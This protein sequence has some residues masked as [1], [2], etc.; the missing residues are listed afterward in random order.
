MTTH[1]ET[2]DLI[3]NYDPEAPAERYRAAG[4]E[5]AL[6]T[7]Q[8]RLPSTVPWPADATPKAAPLE[9]LPSETDSLVRF[10]GY[11][12]VVLTWTAAEAASRAALNTPDY[13]P[14]KWYEYRHAIAD[15]VP[16]VI[17]PRA[18]FN[19]TRADMKRYFHSLGLY[20]PCT[21]GRAKV[22]L[23][24]SGL[25]LDYD[26]PDMPVRKLVA[27][28]TDTIKPKVFITTCTGGRWEQM[29]IWATSLLR[30]RQSFIARRS[31]RNSP[32]RTSRMRR[33]PCPSRH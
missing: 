9:I 18:P 2:E 30:L 5:A 26:G 21:L 12:A 13:L 29:S 8:Q 4:M 3:L 16:L 22:L 19:D 20:F 6:L 10:R 28:L 17:G 15:Y 25:H 23:F 31:S 1:V 14:S 7:T 32:S 33:Q 27:E 11:D 24:K